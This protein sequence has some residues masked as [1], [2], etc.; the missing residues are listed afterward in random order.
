MNKTVVL[1]INNSLF[2]TITF[3]YSKETVIN[4]LR[5]ESLIQNPLLL[6]GTTCIYNFIQ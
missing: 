2:K 6:I 1:R 3:I 4:Y 5:L